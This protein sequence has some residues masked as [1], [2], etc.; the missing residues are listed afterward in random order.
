[1]SRQHPTVPRPAA[2]AIEAAFVLPAVILLI[3]ALVVGGMGVF[4]YQQ[5]ACLAREA[6]RWAA[7]RGADYQKQTGKASPTEA[8]IKQQAVL[9]LAVGIDPSG[10]TVAVEWV[11]NGASTTTA[12]D[13]A[14]RAVKT[15]SASGDYVS[16]SVRVTV[17]YEWSPML[18]PGTIT[19]ISVDQIP[20]SF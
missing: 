20:M 9:P 19:L 11:D 1:M 16:S 18:I 3:L 6:T 8:Q 14:S 4:R 10:L 17:T 15:L 7:V 13:K 2:V 5:V 12:W